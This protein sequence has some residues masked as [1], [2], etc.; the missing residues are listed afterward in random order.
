MQPN[1]EPN[2]KGLEYHFAPDREWRKE[3]PTLDTYVEQATRA[4]I[5]KS[6]S[7]MTYCDRMNCYMEVAKTATSMG[8]LSKV[9]LDNYIKLYALVVE[10]SYEDDENEY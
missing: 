4:L 7:F 9:A 5:L 6:I 1:I 8:R 10:E 2:K 3:H